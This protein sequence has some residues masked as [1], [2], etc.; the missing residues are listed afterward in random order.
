[1]ADP[2]RVAVGA[3]RD[4]LVDERLRRPVEDSAVAQVAVERHPALAR[5]G[6]VEPRPTEEPELC[7]VRPTKEA[8]MQAL[9]G[10]ALEQKL[11]GSRCVSAG[12]QPPSQQVSDNGFTVFPGYPRQRLTGFPPSRCTALRPGRVPRSPPYIAVREL[13]SWSC[14]TR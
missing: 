14:P 11:Q 3:Q 6:V 13:S 4:A 2:D 10:Q 1:M 5:V 7:L 8:L 12:P 9:Q